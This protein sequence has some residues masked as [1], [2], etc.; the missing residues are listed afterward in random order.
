METL[1]LDIGMRPVA[2]IAWTDAIITAL[3]K[4]K[5][6]VIEEYPD[7]YI[8]TVN[9]KVKMPSVIMLV[10]PVKRHGAVKFSRHSI[11][12]RDKGRCQYCGTGVHR[13]EF[14]Y[15]HVIPRAQ[16]GRTSWENIVVS[17]MPCNQKKANRTPAQAGMRLLSQPVRPRSLPL[18][19][20]RDDD[21]H[22]SP[23]MPEAWKS[24]LRSHAYWNTALDEG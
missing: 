6:R 10:L 24:Y 20:A 12:S 5:A 8:S 15:E 9:W 11:Y 16:G 2:R 4:K 22:F 13:R 23:G 21:M 19:G 3:V 17:C 1:V 14:Q 7:R 18:A